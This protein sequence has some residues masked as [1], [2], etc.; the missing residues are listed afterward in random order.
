M[1][2]PA[3]CLTPFARDHADRLNMPAR[4]AA[5][6]LFMLA[7]SVTGGVRPAPD[8][9]Y[10]DFGGLT[11][12]LTC[13]I[14]AFLYLAWVFVSRFVLRQAAKV[15][16][17]AELA[18]TVR[19]GC[20]MTVTLVSFIG[21]VSGASA[22]NDDCPIDFAPLCYRCPVVTDFAPSL[23]DA[24]KLP[25]GSTSS[26]PFECPNT[27]PGAWKLTIANGAYDGS[28]C[29]LDS[30]PPPLPPPHPHPTPPRL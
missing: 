27:C 3:A 23:P 19:F 26:I 6:A 14:L 28:E 16:H 25:I 1:S 11:A 2:H 17:Y 18:P 5:L 13:A 15:D 9:T 4:G 24:C 30:T 10:S 22:I 12:Q 8:H 7:F 29:M 20:D 21:A